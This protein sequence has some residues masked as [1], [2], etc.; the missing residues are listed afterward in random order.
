MKHSKKDKKPKGFS[1]GKNHD[2]KRLGP[3]RIE[4]IL[5]GAPAFSK[6]DLTIGEMMMRTDR[7]NDTSPV[8][9][10]KFKPLDNPSKTSS[11]SFK[12]FS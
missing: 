9:K 7:T 12:E 6:Y 5:D 3:I 11:M 8:I 2:R 1:K 4:D 10:Q